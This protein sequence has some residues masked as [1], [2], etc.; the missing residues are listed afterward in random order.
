MNII[1]PDA[2]LEGIH[3]DYD[4][5]EL[6]VR[7]AIDHPIRVVACGYIGLSIVP[8]WD[9]VMVDRAQ[10]YDRHPFQD[11]CLRRLAPSGTRPDDS[12]SPD[13][14]AWTFQTLE[15]TFIDGATLLCC[16]HRFEAEPT[17]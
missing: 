2:V 6:L 17:S 16:A 15:V 3:V 1:W 13:R 14:N 7:E 5:I 8:V 11:E 12:G 10:I 9:E 4:Q